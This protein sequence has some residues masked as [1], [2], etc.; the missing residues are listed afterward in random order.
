MEQTLTFDVVTSARGFAING[1]MPWL[2]DFQIF[3]DE[4]IG[5]FE[6]LWIEHFKDAIECVM[7]RNAILEGEKLFEPFELCLAE[8]LEIPIRF[9]TAEDGGECNEK[10]FVERIPDGICSF[11]RIIDFLDGLLECLGDF[12][13]FS[14]TVVFL[15][16]VDDL[17][18]SAV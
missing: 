7:R 5:V 14:R 9:G 18:F 15:E 16:G 8:R 12:F 3:D 11:S 10:E 1:D 6:G 17:F 13:D 2:T 4:S